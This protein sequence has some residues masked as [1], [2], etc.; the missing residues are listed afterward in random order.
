MKFRIRFLAIILLLLSRTNT[1]LPAEISDDKIRTWLTPS[2]NTQIYIEGMDDRKGL[3]RIFV[4]AMTSGAD[5]PLYAV[6]QDGELIG[7]ENSGSSF[8]VQPGVYTVVFGTGTLDQRIRR[9]VNVR[10]EETIILNPDWCALTIEVI[11]EVRNYQKQDLQI[12]DVKSAQSYGILPAI[13]PELGEH[14]QTLILPAGLYKIVKRGEDFNTYVNFTTLWL[15][16]GTYTPYT[17]VIEEETDN[18]IGA[19][20]L[21]T[22]GQSIQR[23]NWSI[24][25]ALHGNVILTGANDASSKEIKTNISLISQLDNRLLFDKFPH[26]YLSN[27]LL[28]LGALRQEGAKFQISQDRLRFK[29]TYVYYILGWLGGYSRLEAKTHLF[30]T[31]LRYDERKNVVLLDEADRP[32]IQFGINKV[33]LEPVLYPLELKEGIGVN[34][35][36]LKTFIAHLNLRTGLGYWQT[37][38]KDVYSQDPDVDT[39]FH[40]I[41]DSFPQGLEN[42]LSC[43]FFCPHS[44]ERAAVPRHDAVR[45]AVA[46][47]GE[48]VAPSEVIGHGI[49]LLDVDVPAGADFGA[50]EALVR[51]CGPG[52]VVGE[53]EGVRPVH[54]ADPPLGCVGIRLGEVVERSLVS[55]EE[56]DA[57][58]LPSGRSTARGGLH[59]DSACLLL[60]TRA[61]IGAERHEMAR[62]VVVSGFLTNQ[63]PLRRCEHVVID[64][65]V[66][67]DGHEVEP[68]LES[69][70]G[71]VFVD[72]AFGVARK[73]AVTVRVSP[74]Q[75]VR[76]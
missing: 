37:Y 43:E 35:T 34:L 24:Y 13:N 9:V 17:V 57:V 31:T 50:P 62:V 19:G 27:N 38:N 42:A 33:Q 28:E 64:D 56:H 44:G 47:Q 58:V 21:A 18:F 63:G 11:D 26:Y 3:G 41:S 14:L 12:F 7:E 5:E 29:N 32:H 10:R 6:F 55:G 40:R 71:V 73:V 52:D 48:P 15:E 68:R 76:L 67:G 51:H 45:V 70:V 69:A 66:V 39:L 30:E 4:P 25:G 74:I 53:D 20:I 49:P 36:P 8:F 61:L 2:P 46:H 22:T 23:R 16:P 60:V 1:C 75:L 54:G 65:V 72:L 59:I